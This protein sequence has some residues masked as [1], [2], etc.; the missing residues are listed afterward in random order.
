[1]LN[2]PQWQE[3]HPEFL[4]EAQALLDRAQE[5]VSHLE[6]I[7]DDHDAIDCLMSTLQR[8]SCEAEKASVNCVAEFTRQLLRLMT[9]PLAGHPQQD[10]I[11]HVLKN[12]F[13]L[14][15]WQLELIDPYN[16]VLL[17]DDTEQRE[18]LK[19][20]AAVIGLAAPDSVATSEPPS[21]L[22]HAQPLNTIHH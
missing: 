18:L 21:K 1:M 7:D 5:C 3:R 20:F 19:N 12:C 8:L 14:L 22:A 6:L 16:G 15:A 13:I 2:G 11:L 17:L 4:S 10:S 9:G